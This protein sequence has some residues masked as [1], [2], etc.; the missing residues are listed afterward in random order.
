MTGPLHRNALSIQVLALLLM[1]MPLGCSH[2]YPLDSEPCRAFEELSLTRHDISA[3]TDG[4]TQS[5]LIGEV[6]VQGF[7]DSYFSVFRRHQEALHISRWAWHTFDT[8]AFLREDL[9]PATHAWFDLMDSEA[10]W[11]HIGHIDNPGISLVTTPLRAMPTDQP[12]VS[13]PM[14]PGQGFQFD[15]L[16]N[17][18]VNANEPLW[19]S[20]RS[21]SGEWV[22]V[23]TSYASGWIHSRD[24][25]SIPE[26]LRV[27]W[28]HLP[29]VAFIEEGYPVRDKSGNFLFASR[30]GMVLPLIEAKTDTNNV[31]IAIS[32]GPGGEAIFEAITVPSQ[33]S[34]PVPMAPTSENLATVASSLLGLPYGWGGLFEN[35]DCSAAIR[36]LFMPFGLWLP[37]NSREQSVTGQAVMLSGLSE[38][39][40]VQL[41]LK[42]AVPFATLLHKEGHIALYIGHEDGYPVVL[43]SVWDLMAKTRTGETRRHVGRIVLSRLRPSSEDG[44]C[45]PGTTLLADLDSMNTLA[46]PISNP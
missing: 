22:F 45:G 17:S 41:I 28:P 19:L 8:G 40:K 26:A 34:V 27:S 33:H 11:E 25:A 7:L 30:I 1:L 21:R 6:S 31:L 39:E 20:H 29:H 35:R 15:H 2:H 43:H 4:S 3:F 46:A 18:L 14:Q 5:R 24:A 44:P 37:R 16:Q 12:L 10:A 32:K 42:E 9:Q 13:D 23:F 36:D 38:D